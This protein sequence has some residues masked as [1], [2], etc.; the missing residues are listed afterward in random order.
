MSKG[1]LYFQR[2][3]ASA[4]HLIRI[5]SLSVSLAGPSSKPEGRKGQEV[6]HSM[7]HFRD[8]FERR[9]EHTS[10][11]MITT[12]RPMLPLQLGVLA[13]ARSTAFGLDAV[14]SIGYLGPSTE[15]YTFTLP[16]LRP[17]S[18]LMSKQGPPSK[19]KPSG[20]LNR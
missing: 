3:R 2:E 20:H 5:V 19:T 9:T 12:G 17:Y 16:P 8:S 7:S 18:L 10:L 11:A 6:G 13:T 14:G 1:D 4:L 15:T